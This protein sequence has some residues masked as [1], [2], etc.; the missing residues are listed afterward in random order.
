MQAKATCTAFMREIRIL[1][2]EEILAIH[3]D[4]LAMRPRP[5][6]HLANL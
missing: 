1:L 5:C 3:H 2:Y 6:P 4:S